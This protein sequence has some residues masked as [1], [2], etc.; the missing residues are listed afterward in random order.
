MCAYLPGLLRWFTA[1]S[2]RVGRGVWGDD[3]MPNVFLGLRVRVI[4]GGAVLALLGACSAC[5]SPARPTEVVKTDVPRGPV[6]PTL[7]VGGDPEV[8]VGPRPQLTPNAQP[9]TS[10]G[11]AWSEVS[12]T[13]SGTAPVR[14]SPSG[15]EI[16]NVVGPPGEPAGPPGEPAGPPGIPLPCSARPTS[17]S[18]HEVRPLACRSPRPSSSGVATPLL[19]PRPRR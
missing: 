9:G 12:A 6:P 4:G 11:S 5:S 1:E 19:S 17:L 13:R 7:V 18:A 10:A 8:R 16:T 14:S 2:A 3:G 15:G